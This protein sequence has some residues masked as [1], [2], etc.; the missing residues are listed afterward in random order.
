MENTELYWLNI[1]EL[2]LKVR[3]C[4]TKYPEESEKIFRVAEYLR[5]ESEQY[6]L[7]VQNSDESISFKDEI[8]KFVYT[9]D[10]YRLAKMVIEMLKDDQGFARP[11]LFSMN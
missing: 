4:F 10:Y 5:D 9:C 8:S 6:S 2:K 7:D 3:E 1:Y 11:E